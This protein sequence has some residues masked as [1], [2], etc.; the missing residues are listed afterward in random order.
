MR[1]HLGE[2]QHCF[3]AD[4]THADDLGISESGEARTRFSDGVQNLPRESVARRELL[5]C[6]ADALVELASLLIARAC[7]HGGGL[8][9]RFRRDGR[10]DRRRDLR[11][12]RRVAPHDARHEL[13]RLG[14]QTLRAVVRELEASLEGS[15]DEVAER[16]RDAPLRTLCSELGVELLVAPALA[17]EEPAQLSLDALEG[18]PSLRP[19]LPV[20]EPIA[21]VG[22]DEHHLTRGQAN[23]DATDPSL[24]L[25]TLGGG[26]RSMLLLQD[27]LPGSLSKDIL[28]K[29]LS[30]GAVAGFVNPRCTKKAPG[31]YQVTLST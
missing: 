21:A 13:R 25:P 17:R 16:T 6:V 31:A 28:G 11:P 19:R 12:G 22:R 20:S 18:D 14:A 3:P 2:V 15:I 5:V 8:L 24:D 1:R 23:V 10:T 7:C 9:G 27:F 4:V 30:M 29:H 26:I